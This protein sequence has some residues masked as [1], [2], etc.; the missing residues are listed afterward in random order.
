MTT[1]QEHTTPLL[2]DQYYYIYNLGNNKQSIFFKRDNYRYFQFKYGHYMSNIVDT[3]AWVL[4][5]NAFHLVV[6]VKSEK[7]ILL[8]ARQ[9]NLKVD[10]AFLDKYVWKFKT[11]TN[12]LT[13]EF[14]DL[15][16]FKNLLNLATLLKIRSTVN[17]NESTENLTKELAIWV[18]SQQMRRFLLSYSK[19]INKQQKRTG[20]LFQKPFRRRTIEDIHALKKQIGFIHYLPVQ[21]GYASNFEQYNWSSFNQHVFQFKNQTTDNTIKQLF[22]SQKDYEQYHY[23][24]KR[25]KSIS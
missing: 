21:Y 20:S 23:L 3:L 10:K 2:P 16:N 22:V 8:E 15:T 9:L 12:Q 25:L 11:E 24:Y 17:G 5:D 4:L 6:K 14:K 7:A 19:S 1:L 13:D 18:V